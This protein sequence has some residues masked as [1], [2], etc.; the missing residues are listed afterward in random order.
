MFVRDGDDER[1]DCMCECAIE[2]EKRCSVCE[3]V[4]QEREGAC[5]VRHVCSHSYV[6]L[7]IYVYMFAIYDC[8]FGHRDR[9][10]SSSYRSIS[11]CVACVSCIFF[12]RR[13]P[14]HW[15][16]RLVDTQYKQTIC[17]LYCIDIRLISVWFRVFCLS[18]QHTNAKIYLVTIRVRVLA[19]KYT[20]VHTGAP[21]RAHTFIMSMSHLLRIAQ[22][23]SS[24]IRIWIF[25]T[26]H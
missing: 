17:L 6:Y 23:I 20:S 2:N 3:C 9:P 18:T 11:M 12:Y 24:C 15:S 25:H 21:H 8:V 7:C 16:H 14:K 13:K 10:F 1:Y 5:S 4:G 22:Y 26:S 19:G